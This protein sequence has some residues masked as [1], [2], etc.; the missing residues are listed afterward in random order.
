MRSILRIACRD[1][2][3]IVYPSARSAS[4]IPGSACGVLS[5]ALWKSTMLPGVMFFSTRP[6]ISS[7]DMPFQ[8]RLSTFHCTGVMP[9]P[10]MAEIT[11]SSYSPYGQRNSV[12]VTPVTAAIFSLQPVMSDTICSSLNCEKCA[13]LDEWFMTSFPA[14]L[15][16]LTDSGYLSTQSPTTKNVVCMP[17]LSSMSISCCVSSL[18]HAA[19]N[20]SATTLSSRWTE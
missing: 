1:T 18:P 15:S 7:A 14:S 17:Y 10:R 19:S 13:W 11:W 20:D 12:G 6:C 16:A 2:G 8:S 3:T 4:I 5:A 9:M